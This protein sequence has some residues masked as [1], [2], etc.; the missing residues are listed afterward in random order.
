VSAPE[1][2]YQPEA[3]EEATQ[4]LRDFITQARENGDTLYLVTDPD[5]YLTN[6]DRYGR[7]LA[8]LWA[9]DKPFYF[10]DELNPLFVPSRS[11]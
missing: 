9:G 3:A 4:R 11:K 8:V 5:T 6:T 7:M 2:G 10:E 1:Y